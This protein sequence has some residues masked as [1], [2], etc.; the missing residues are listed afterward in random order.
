MSSEG[1][2]LAFPPGSLARFGE[3]DDAREWVQIANILLGSI[4]SGELRPGDV[5]GTRDA[6]SQEYGC[7]GHTALQALNA[8]EDRGLLR[9]FPHKG[10]V[11]VLPPAPAGDGD[12]A[13][14][15]AM[16]S[17]A[18]DPRDWVRVANAVLARIRSGTY[19]DGPVRAIDLAAEFGLCRSTAGR[20]LTELVTLGI[21]ELLPG[22]GYFVRNDDGRQ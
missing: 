18:G 8:L 14:S 21:L 1:N 10:H 15:P 19:H 3:R 2:L 5:A 16:I 22:R 4:A 6:L 20:A 13:G 12:D 11:V 17:Q 7:T 9:G